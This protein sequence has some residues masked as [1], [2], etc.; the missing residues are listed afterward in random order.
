MTQPWQIEILDLRHFGASQ[1]RSLLEQEAQVW[2]R[3]LHWDYQSSI[4]L[5]LQYLDSR[6]LLGFVALANGR[7][8][9]YT[10]F[11]YEGTKAVIGDL[12]ISG[13]GP[14][15]P[16]VAR[17]LA[18]HLLSV[19]EASPDV[20]RIE[21]Q[22][23]LY[24]ADVLT[25]LFP[26]FQVYRRLFLERHLELNS[27]APM[28]AL[29]SAIPPDL[30]LCAWTSVF[31]EPSAQLIQA[32]YLGHIDSDIN[33]Q[34]RTLEGSLRFLHNVVR[35]PGC[36]VFDPDASWVFRSRA[37]R[38]LVA[39]ILCSR[40]A[41]VSK[42][43]PVAHVTQLCVAPSY[44]GRGIGRILLEICLSMLA[45]RGYRALTLTVTEENTA[46]LKLYLSSNFEVRR[47]F[48]ALVRQKGT[49]DRSARAKPSS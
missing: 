27:R 24:E 7:V 17:H 40:I 30:E 5:L 18:E 34:Y 12:Y 33:D 26:G 1:L 21:A 29:A 22:L 15:Q 42:D 10:F 13:E 25:P 41:P 3:L 16:L 39:I 43:G 35:F 28:N 14:A 4:E 8:S 44:C 47:G 46:A 37:T 11:V 31:Y 48:D 2:L 6:I 9:G 20:D 19:L 32:A 49:L 38:T 23:L 36:G 45:A